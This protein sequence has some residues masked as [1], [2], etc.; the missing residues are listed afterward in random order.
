[1]VFALDLAAARP[2]GAREGWARKGG[3]RTLGVVSPPPPRCS[4][5]SQGCLGGVSVSGVRASAGSQGRLGWVGRGLCPAN[6]SVEAARAGVTYSSG[7]P[8][9]CEALSPRQAASVVPALLQC[10]RLPLG[11]PGTHS[12]KG[13]HFIDTLL[14]LSSALPREMGSCAVQW[15]GILLEMR[16]TRCVSVG[17]SEEWLSEGKGPS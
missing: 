6:W 3:L 13:W 4:W 16:S 10:R 8:L 2:L 5:P 14:C 15:R 7:P 11:A 12:A 17:S 9:L 1:M